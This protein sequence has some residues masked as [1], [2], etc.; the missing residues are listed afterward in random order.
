[1]RDDLIVPREGDVDG[2]VFAM[3]HPLVHE[4]AYRSLLIARRKVLH[5]RIGEWLEAHEGEDALAA[6]ASHYREGDDLERARRFLP[7]AAER[8]VRLNAPREA[9][10]TYLAA[11]DLFTD[12]AERAA[13]LQPGRIS[14]TSSARS[15][16]RSS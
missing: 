5:R 8:A 3:R 13:M 12:P 6:I 2:R 10:D 15:R 1:M 9:R 16:A 7:L 11:A 4:V 14:A